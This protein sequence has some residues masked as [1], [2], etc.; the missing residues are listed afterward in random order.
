MFWVIKYAIVGTDNISFG[1]AMVGFIA[2]TF[3]MSVTSGGIGLYPLAIASVY[4]LF[5]ILLKLVKLLVGFY[6]QL[7][8]Y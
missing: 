5:D 2:G 7:K 4:K 6:G 8:P 3:A 1:A